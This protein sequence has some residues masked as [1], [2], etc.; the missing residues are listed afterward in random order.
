[1][2]AASTSTTGASG[3][4]VTVREHVDARAPGG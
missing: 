4:L 1:M 3:T 2:H